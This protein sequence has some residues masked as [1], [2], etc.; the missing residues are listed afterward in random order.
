MPPPTRLVARNARRTA[1]ELTR[2]PLN[3]PNGLDD[4]LLHHML[5][6]PRCPYCFKLFKKLRDCH[7]HQSLQPECRAA[8]DLTLHVEVLPQMRNNGK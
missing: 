3:I 8:A 6:R 4:Q 5:F 7:H 2:M 1:V